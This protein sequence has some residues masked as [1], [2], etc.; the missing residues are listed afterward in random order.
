MLQ[1]VEKVVLAFVKFYPDRLPCK[2]CGWFVSRYIQSINRAGL[3]YTVAI[4][5]LA[6][7]EDSEIALMRGR[8]RSKG[9]N[10]ALPFDTSKVNLKEIP[11]YV[12]WRLY[13]K[14]WLSVN[15]SKNE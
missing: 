8:Q 3:G 1:N 13:G 15:L 14:N 5:H 11:D 10:G 7:M 12:D 4:N 2:P 9:Y 6:D